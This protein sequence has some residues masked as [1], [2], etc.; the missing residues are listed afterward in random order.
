MLPANGLGKPIA[1][2]FSRQFSGQIA[3]C[4]ILSSIALRKP[5]VA[6]KLTDSSPQTH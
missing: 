3:A 4:A 5:K 1:R 2:P 6:E